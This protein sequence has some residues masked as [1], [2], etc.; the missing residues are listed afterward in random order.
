MSHEVT[1]ELVYGANFRG[2]LNH[3]SSL[4]RFKESWGQLRPKTDPNQQTNITNM[5]IFPR[6]STTFFFGERQRR[7]RSRGRP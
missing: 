2:V 7:A 1:L 5:I 6:G 3:F 4:T